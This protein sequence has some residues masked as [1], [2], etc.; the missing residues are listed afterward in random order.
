ML[1]KGNIYSN[2]NEN[3]CIAP[4]RGSKCGR[5]KPKKGGTKQVKRI[6]NLVTRFLLFLYITERAISG[7]Y[8]C[9]G[10]AWGYFSTKTASCSGG[11]KRNALGCGCAYVARGCTS[12]WS[13]RR[14]R[15]TRKD[16]PLCV[17][18]GAAS[19]VTDVWTY[20]GTS[21][22]HGDARPCAWPGAWWE[23]PSAY[24]RMDTSCN[25]SDKARSLCESECGR[26]CWPCASWRSC[27]AGSRATC[28]PLT[29]GG[30]LGCPI[31]LQNNIV[32]R[33][34]IKTNCHRLLRN[35]LHTCD[36]LVL[37]LEKQVSSYAY[38]SIKECRHRNC[39]I[40][41]LQHKR[42]LLKRNAVINFDGPQRA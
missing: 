8:G 38:H 40:D 42:H 27:T 41:W 37:W 13:A 16:V 15:R 36:I 11:R 23:A 22:K 12:W 29:N 1:P 30:T 18:A 2:S 24:L 34:T 7:K 17:W 26:S 25:E 28:V 14:T 6:T 19:G 9:A 21:G 32:R 3:R 33:N 10:G 4:R 39:M 5:N 31:H 35:G 20:W